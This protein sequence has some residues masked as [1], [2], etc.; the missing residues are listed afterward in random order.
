MLSKLWPKKSS[1][2]KKTLRELP[3]LLNIPGLLPVKSVDVLLA[4]YSAKLVQINEL[5][6][7]SQS[8]F[9]R[10][11]LSA[12]RNFARFVQQ[13]PASEVHHHAGP[14]GMLTHTLEVC[15][16]ALKIRRS[17]LLSETGGAE[18]IAAKQ[19]LWS[20]AVFL[21]ALCHDLAKVAVDQQIT[22]YDDQYHAMTWDP[23]ARFLDEQGRWYATEFVRKRQYGLHEKATPLLVHK[24]ISAHGMNWL[25]SDRTIFSRWLACVSGDLHNASSLGEIV[26]V[27]DGQSVAANLGADGSRMPAVKTIPLH[28]K[29][30]TALRFLLLEGELPLNRNG[31][32]GW[33]KGK[34]CW[35]VSKRTVDA[36]RDQLTREGH[37]GIPTK[38]G[39]LFDVLQ[40]HGVLTP[41]GGKAI[42]TANV[43]GEGWRN[44]LTLIKIAVFKIWTHSDRRPD[45]FEGRV[46]PLEIKEGVESAETQPM[47]FYDEAVS[48]SLSETTYTEDVEEGVSFPIS[49]SEPSAPSTSDLDLLNFLPST[50]EDSDDDSHRIRRDKHYRQAVTGIPITE[51]LNAKIKPVLASNPETQSM[52]ECNDPV[53]AFFDWLRDGIKTGVIKTNQPKA[54]VHIVNEG[55][56][57]MTP[58]VFQDFSQSQDNPSNWTAIQKKVLKKNWHVK[59]EQGLNV[60]KYQVKGANKS[61]TVNVILFEDVSRI[62][63]DSKP[64][65]CNPHLK[66]VI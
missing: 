48:A 59:D 35:L 28:E 8:H 4:P 1:V 55:V 41:C 66:K 26:N 14:G 23:W 47:N 38:N 21:A 31:A 25:T 34:D 52:G 7:L 56:A 39:R 37:S 6:G 16:N 12:I 24:I 27:A 10:F 40:E 18:E 2:D 57:L 22:V 64:P 17:Y 11:Y 9:D 19:D 13:L 46:I 3:L 51:K 44:E 30:L 63:G 29:M 32:A 15:V 49:E 36:I 61:T 20:Y 60:I 43:E 45:E 33:I 50:A 54:R 5:A 58:G 65:T 62:F 42:W 53:D